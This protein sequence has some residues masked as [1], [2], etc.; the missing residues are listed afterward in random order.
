MKKQYSKPGIIIEDFRVAEH[1]ASCEGVKHDN[2]WGRPLQW[3]PTNCPWY[4]EED[5]YVFTSQSICTD[6][7]SENGDPGY[8]GGFCYNGAAGGMSVFGS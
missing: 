4:N 3:S 2:Y 1:I 7:W 5:G 8:V 6:I